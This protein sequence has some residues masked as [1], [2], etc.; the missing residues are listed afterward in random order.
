MAPPSS[1]I[2]YIHRKTG[3]LRA[4][5]VYGERGLH[6]LYETWWGSALLHTFIKRN[7]FSHLTGFLHRSPL[8]RRKILSFVEQFE[9]DDSESEFPATTYRSLDAF[10][11]RKLK[12]EARPIDPNPLHLV[13]P[14]E[15]RVLAFAEIPGGKLDVKGCTVDIEELVGGLDGFQLGAGFVIRLAPCDYHRFHFPANCQ[16]SDPVRVG[17]VLHSVHPIALKAGAPAF[18]NKRMVSM[19]SD[20][21]CGRMLQIEVGA[22]TVGSIVQTYD[23]G[24]VKRGQEK[25]YFRFGGSTVILL[26]EPGRIRPDDDLLDATERGLETL[27][28]VGTRI[29]LIADR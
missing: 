27:V 17:R 1:E 9:I 18:R 25:G 4:E 21:N 14:A 2:N 16:V 29:G 15:G 7:W 3:E 28:N 12:P 24:P 23:R 19:L 13:A 26:T 11:T 22:L 20:T 10:F 5:R 6:L 8:S